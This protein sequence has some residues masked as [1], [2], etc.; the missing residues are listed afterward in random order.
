MKKRVWNVI[1]WNLGF[2]FLFVTYYLVNHWTGFYIPCVF[3]LITG[4]QCPGCGITHSLF[5]IVKLD[6]KS[7]FHY[8]P[9]AFFFL[10]F[11]IIYYI[12]MTYLYIYQKKDRVL[13]RIPKAFGV[14][15]I[16]ITLLYGILRNI[17]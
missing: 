14:C 4:Y 10:P 3:R 12:Y 17:Y 6:F 7:A 1:K 13:S 15:L 11:F 5:S 9:L 8:N 16:L 2:F